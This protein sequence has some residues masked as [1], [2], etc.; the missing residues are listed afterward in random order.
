[1]Q[2]G[3][4]GAV[5]RCKHI[6]Y[7]EHVRYIRTNNPKS[8]YAAHILN[9]RHEYGTAQ[10]TLQLLQNCQKGTRMD[11]WET[12][13]MQAL[14]QQKVLIDEQQVND[15]NPLLQVAIVT[16]AEPHPT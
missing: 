12:L 7:K 13:Y 4:C 3:I 10:E 9:N 8:A 6:R 2:Q 14:H 15:I 16:Q 5:G 1:M 11:C